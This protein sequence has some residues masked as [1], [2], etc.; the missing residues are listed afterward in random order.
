MYKLI[1]GLFQIILLGEDSQDDSE[2][3]FGDQ[4]SLLNHHT[5]L[6][7]V[8]H[9]PRS[10]VEVAARV[11]LNN[12]NATYLAGDALFSPQLYHSAPSVRKTAQGAT[13]P[14]RR[15]NDAADC[16]PLP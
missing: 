15:K 12:S 3:N 6:R 8:P 4:K 1:G 10:G 13:C 11:F 2:N 7:I 5:G 16:D 14:Q 9:V